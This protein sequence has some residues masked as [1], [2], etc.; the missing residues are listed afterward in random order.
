MVS[1]LI[2]HQQ[3]QKFDNPNKEDIHITPSGHVAENGEEFYM[4]V[5]M[6]SPDWKMTNKTVSKIGITDEYA[7][8]TLY[9]AQKFDQEFLE[10]RKVQSYFS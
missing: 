7:L 3:L 6:L 10:K 2:K 5:N 9:Y 4:F 8:K 1:H